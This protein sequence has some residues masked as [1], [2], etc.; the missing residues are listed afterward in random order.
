MSK[1]NLTKKDF[2]FHAGT[3]FSNNELRSHGGRVLNFTSIGNKFKDIRQKILSNIRKLNWS[4]GFYRRDIGWKVIN[5][6]EN[7]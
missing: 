6:N 5:K 4:K 3:Y 7:N 2:I 1:L